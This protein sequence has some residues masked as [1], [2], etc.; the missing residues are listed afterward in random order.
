MNVIYDI[1]HIRFDGVYCS[2]NSTFF[3]AN[4]INKKK[5]FA[6]NRSE[7]F[8]F[9]TRCSMYMAGLTLPRCRLQMCRASERILTRSIIHCTVRQRACSYFPI[10]LW[11][12]ISPLFLSHF[13]F[14]SIFFVLISLCTH[15]FI[16]S[17]FIK[18]RVLLLLLLLYTNVVLHCRQ[19]YL[20]DLVGAKIAQLNCSTCA[21]FN[22]H[23]SSNSNSDV[24]LRQYFA[25]STRA[26]RL[27]QS[28]LKNWEIKI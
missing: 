18:R 28:N 3:M 5:K 7:K 12:T 1:E 15:S 16:R 24:S 21:S 14:L 20:N 6:C 22:I 13:R 4:Q 2:I 10:E 26:N 23:S 19:I 17:S 9:N 27:R 25:N 11:H 8:I